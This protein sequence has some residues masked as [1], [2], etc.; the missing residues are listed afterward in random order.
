MKVIPL[1][2]LALLGY[3][4]TLARVCS[5]DDTLRHYIVF[6]PRPA[7]DMN[8]NDALSTSVESEVTSMMNLANAGSSGS[9]TL[10]A[11]AAPVEF[12]YVFNH[13]F[14][15]CAL[16]LTEAMA[17]TLNSFPGVRVVL[18]GTTEPQTTHT[19]EFLGLSTGKLWPQSKFGENV[20]VGVIDGGVW[21]ESQSFS[22]TGMG[23]IP[24][25][26]KGVCEVG[27]RFT[28]ANCNKKLIGARFFYKG[29]QAA[30]GIDLTTQVLSP[31]DTSGHGTHC[32]STAAGSAVVGASM[33]GFGSG[34]PARGMASGARLAVYKVCWRTCY[35][36]DALAAYDQAVRDGVDVISVSLGGRPANYEDEAN[37]VASFGAMKAG[38]FV[39]QSAG[40]SGGTKSTVV[41]VGP[42]VMTV[43]A[44]TVDRLFYVSVKLGNGV[45]LRG[46]SWTPGVKVARLLIL[47]SKVAVKGADPL[48]A[49]NCVRG[50]LSPALLKASPGKMVVCRND[51]Y[52]SVVEKGVEVLAAGGQGMIIVDNAE[53]DL[54][55]RFPVNH[56]LP[57][58]HVGKSVGDTI[59][60]YMNSTKNPTAML[61]PTTVV[62]VKPAPK[63]AS[64]SSRGPSITHPQILKPDITGPGVF[65]LAAWQENQS[66]T[67]L[68][69]D[70]NRVKFNVISGTSMSTPHIAGLAALLR[71]AHPTW[72]P[73]MI[74]S[75]LMTTA[76]IA[77]NRSPKQLMLDQWTSGIATP[78]DYGA[79]HV[80]PELA[81]NPGLVYDLRPQDY[82][83]YLCALGYP[84]SK[85]QTFTGEPVMC[86][87][88]PARVEDF[89]YP[90]F[91]ATFTQGILSP[92]VV[93]FT[94]ILTNVG[95]QSATYQVNVKAPTG[96]SVLV[97][98][99]KLSFTPT[100]KSLKFTVT[101]TMVKP[102]EVFGSLTW[103][104]GTILVRSPIVITPA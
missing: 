49:S 6:K 33:N 100:A 32:A 88:P 84:S 5:L 50:T 21:P 34:K 55:I 39:A 36:S 69:S 18:D 79:G 23:P 95:A 91:T 30:E 20:I 44:S 4:S 78:F 103:T 92:L 43:G 51:G 74:K 76:S 72:S 81:L 77:D 94:R 89:N 66:P 53:L 96:A 60:T 63:I 40:N 15:G 104:D 102:A 11:N 59:L 86:P 57:T 13:A 9:T 80:T 71:G 101:V 58:V 70:P 24:A 25:R 87:I 61:S 14:R 90:T 29:H 28:K 1:C 7:G 2:L 27:T 67:E 48:K 73:A 83:N 85:V 52:N 93:T 45:G 46:I 75:A 8:V 65:I 82:I 54:S 62:G 56:V 16:K 26:W 10:G 98:P 19:P 97:Q 35:D 41:N 68:A 38:I 37:A 64:F 3:F 17:A 22:D 31:R 47:A 12:S 99:T 42:W